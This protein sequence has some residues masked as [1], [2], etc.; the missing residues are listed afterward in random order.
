[1]IHLIRPE[2]AAVKGRAVQ[3]FLAVLALTVLWLGL[4]AWLPWVQGSGVAVRVSIHIAIALGL[5]LA[6]ENSGLAPRQRLA[7]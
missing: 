1:M 5:W 2:A 4:N 3:L 6:L 7:T